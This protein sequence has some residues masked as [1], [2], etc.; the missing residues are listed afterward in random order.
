MFSFVYSSL[1][2]AISRIYVVVK[3]PKNRQ[4]G[5][6]TFQMRETEI[7]DI[8]F[9]SSWLISDKQMAKYGSVPFGD[10]HVKSQN[11]REVGP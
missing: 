11:R 7:F 2:R 8:H 9:I 1:F 10:I 6:L 5:R 3:P 4:F